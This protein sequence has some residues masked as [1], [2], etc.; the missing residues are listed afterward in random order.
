MCRCFCPVTCLSRQFLFSKIR[1]SVSKRRLK[2]NYFQNV[3]DLKSNLRDNVDGL[4]I[5]RNRTSD[6]YALIF[7]FIYTLDL[8]K[9]NE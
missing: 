6:L 1:L 9:K 8:E 4:M 3:N 5:W 2:K 7:D